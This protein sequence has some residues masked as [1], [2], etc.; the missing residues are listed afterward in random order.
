MG[1]RPTPPDAARDPI[2]PSPQSDPIRGPIPS[3][4]WD[5]SA[6]EV[7]CCGLVWDCLT[8]MCIQSTDPPDPAHAP[9]PPPAGGIPPPPP[10]P[11]NQLDPGRHLG[12]VPL[13]SDPADNWMTLL[14]NMDELL[15]LLLQDPEAPGSESER[16]SPSGGGGSRPDP[17]TAV[18]PEERVLRLEAHTRA[19]HSGEMNERPAGQRSGAGSGAGCEMGSGVGSG[20]DREQAVARG[21]CQLYF[22]CS[23]NPTRWR[24]GWHRLEPWALHQ[25]VRSGVTAS[26]GA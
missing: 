23:G 13:G 19:A 3:R 26:A 7:R 2:P 11:A 1:Y 5:L 4:A 6:L 22:A 9:L 12:C 20:M 24:S 14:P 21:L 15:C 10:D 8:S 25:L 17:A 18:D 16:G